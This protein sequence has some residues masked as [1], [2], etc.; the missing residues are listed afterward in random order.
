MWAYYYYSVALSI[1]D[2][3]FISYSVILYLH[4]IY[5]H[6]F[7]NKDNDYKKIQTVF[8][9]KIKLYIYIQIN[10]LEGYLITQYQN[11]NDV[12]NCVITTKMLFCCQQF[13]LDGK[14]LI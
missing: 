5:L 8:F 7:T 1:L 3:W 13:T 10:K 12:L 9:F 4:I 14:N 11:N 2:I 6:S